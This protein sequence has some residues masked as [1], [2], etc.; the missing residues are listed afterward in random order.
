MRNLIRLAIIG[1]PFFLGSCAEYQK[2]SSSYERTYSA[3]YNAD[4][5]SGQVSLTLRPISP[6]AQAATPPATLND[7]VIAKI[8]KLIM[9]SKSVTPEVVKVVD[10]KQPVE[11]LLK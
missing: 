6:S 8:V 9:E 1:V 2:F 11:A 4:T 7:E 10:F 5:G 3:G